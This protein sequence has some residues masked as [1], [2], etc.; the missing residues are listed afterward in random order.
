[1]GE[2]R[3]GNKLVL[4][5]VIALVLA[6]VAGALNYFCVSGGGS[7]TVKVL[8]YAKPISL[9]K[10]FASDDFTTVNLSFKND[11]G[12]DCSGYYRSVFRTPDEAS[13]LVGSMPTVPRE[14]GQIVLKSDATAGNPGPPTYS[15]FGDFL[16]LGASGNVIT[17]KAERDSNGVFTEQTNRLIQ[18]TSSGGAVENFQVINIVELGNSREKTDASAVR[19]ADAGDERSASEDESSVDDADKITVALPKTCLVS[20]W[21]QP[22]ARVAFVVPAVILSDSERRRNS[23]R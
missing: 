1:M 5:F 12:V 22:G 15:T 6:I 23:K 13:L 19:P 7:K 4:R 16:V 21:L 3:E 9:G 2:N 18:L 14:A 11:R 8:A 17:V 20:G 10:A